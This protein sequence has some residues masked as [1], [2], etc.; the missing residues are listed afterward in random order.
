MLGSE[1]LYSDLL[2]RFNDSKASAGGTTSVI[3]L[4][5][6]GGCV[7]RDDDF[8]RQQK[9]AQ[10]REYFFGDR[11]NTLS[12]HTQQIDFGQLN[13]YKLVDTSSND[14]SSSLL[15]GDYDLTA[16]PTQSC[17]EKVTAPTAQM[18]NAVVAIVHAEPNDTHEAIRDA[19]TIGF[20]FVAEV[21]EKKGKLKILSP[22]SGRLP[23]KAMVWGRWPEG[24]A[25]FVG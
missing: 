11:K 17:F 23:Q 19:S 25:E 4:E 9:Q 6:S 10:I 18:Q 14:V 3:K 8:R 12:P 20:I 13:I 15:P 16:S 5:K 2:R 1:R 24:S 7:D 21:D 22:L